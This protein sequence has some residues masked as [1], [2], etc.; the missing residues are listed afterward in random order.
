LN[1]I[2]PG[3][4]WVSLLGKEHGKAVYRVTI[5]TRYQGSFDIAL[6]VNHEISFAEIL[7]EITWLIQVGTTAGDRKL[8]EDFGGYWDEYDL[9]SEEFIPGETAGKFI[10]RMIRQQDQTMNERLS[11]IWPYLI[12][13]GVS[14]YVQF[15]RRTERRLELKDP[16]P[17]NIIIPKHD[18]QTGSRIVSISARREHLNPLDMLKNFILCYIEEIE[19]QYGILKGIG[20][21]K[22]IFSAIIEALG[23]KKGIAFLNDCIKLLDHKGRKNPEKQLSDE[24]KDYLSS[25][26]EGG[27]IP[28]RLYFAIKR[29]HRW[30]SLSPSATNLARAATLSELYETYQLNLLE[31]EYP[32]TRTRFFRDTVFAHSEKELRSSLKKIIAEQQNGKIPADRFTQHISALQ[33]SIRLN[34]KELLFLTR[35]SYPHLQP[36]DTADLISLEKGGVSHTDI[37]IQTKDY[38]GGS[39]YIRGPVNPKEISRLHQLFL[40]NNLA[41]Q[42]RLDHMFLVA[43]NERS[44]LIGGLFYK[45]NSEDTVHIEKIVVAD[46]YRKKGVSDGLLRE[47]FLRM[48]NEH[49]Y[50]VTTGF[51]RP[52]YFYRFGFKVE[53]KYAGLVK[54]LKE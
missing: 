24:L 5:Q 16:S 3:G 54:D 53:R 11:Q 19:N 43:V 45:K 15:W 27:F 49:Y 32:E 17:I 47:F 23:H 13:S 22:Y 14:A 25:V 39:F 30:R 37:V 36:T 28:K 48:K 35:L 26:K 41:V 7:D 38:D 2:P 31:I 42:F 51:F 1:D 33:K 4:L 9:W 40:K 29:Y 8:V 44:Q 12:W 6:N 52:E 46:F 34:E 50:F 20:K 18:Y 21:N 10:S